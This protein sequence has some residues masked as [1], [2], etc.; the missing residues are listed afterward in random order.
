MLQAQQK[1]RYKEQKTNNE[2][3]L[4]ARSTQR[5]LQQLFNISAASLTSKWRS[6]KEACV[7]SPPIIKRSKALVSS[8]RSEEEAIRPTKKTKLSS[9]RGSNDVESLIS[10]S[11]EEE[12]DD[13]SDPQ[14]DTKSFKAPA[15]F[16]S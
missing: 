8:N 1:I 16:S 7:K 13:D 12:E 10:S 11:S 14:E 5:K 4:M 6:S 15:R 3:R 2:Q 9:Q